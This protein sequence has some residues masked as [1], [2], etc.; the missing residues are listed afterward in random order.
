MPKKI[1]FITGTRADFGKLSSLID[2]VTENPFFEYCIFVT[3]MH[4]L[5]R[6]GYTVDEVIKKYSSFRLDGGF[7][8]VH[9]FM[10][11]IHGEAMDVILANTIM[12]LSRY[13]NEYQP[14]M[15]VVHGDRVETLA[16]SIVGSLRNILVAHIEG[17]EVSGTIDE[18]IRHSVSKLAHIHFVSN[19]DSKG[20]LLQMGEASESIHVI[21]SPDIDLM[22][23][24]HLPKLNEALSYYKIPFN[25]YAIT[26]LH[27][28]TTDIKQT[29]QLAKNTVDAML[30]S[31]DNYITI[32]PNNDYGSDIILD[33]FERLK[34]NNKIVIY[35]SIRMQ[36]FLTLLRES[37][38]LLGN[39][40][41]G[42]RETP[43]YSI[44]S[45][46]LGSRQQGRSS[47]PSIINSKSDYDCI[48]QSIYQA[49]KMVV[50][51]PR[52][53]FGK[54]DSAQKFIDIL[55]QEETWSTCIQKSF[56]SYPNCILENPNI[57]Q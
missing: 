16:A 44:P 7:R 28:V 21:G 54:G 29:K 13:V 19:E 33:E 51:T 27:P 53:D 34:G 39:S 24:P 45:I 10:N 49:K 32:Y 47:C 31:N 37:Q 5:K 48:M 6:Y 25:K 18:V 36:Y 3:G 9:V 38:Y 1:L 2:K 23:S 46:N 50:H 8:N 26:L 55:G 40:S 22:L 17:G 42:I 43:V 56:I 11:Q 57:N 41:A 12:G 14:D 35:P 20:R 30:N 15:I 52:F 4:T